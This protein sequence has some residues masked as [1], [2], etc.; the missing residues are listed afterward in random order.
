M[1]NNIFLPSNDEWK[2]EMNI[3]KQILKKISFKV[4][5][6]LQK[7]VSIIE[8]KNQCDLEK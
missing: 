4:G 3:A 1:N 7:R 2:E 8:R 6:S 5:K